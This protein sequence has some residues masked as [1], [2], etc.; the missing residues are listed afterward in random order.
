MARR[1]AKTAKPTKRRRPGRPPKH[2]GGD[3]ADERFPDAYLIKRYGNRRLYDARKSRA[4][5]LEGIAELVRRGEKVLVVDGDSGED[6]TRR[7]LTQILL[8]SQN[9]RLLELMPVELL[10]NLVSMRE[11]P[12]AK[13]METYLNAGAR[14]VNQLGKAGPDAK[15][16]KESMDNFFPWV[17]ADWVAPT[18]AP[19]ADE[20]L[21]DEMAE[22]QQRLADL[23]ARVN[24][25][26]R[27]KK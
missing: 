12:I 9:G 14:F 16:L 15:G 13:W 23:S 20:G 19:A 8:E 5:S 21:R 22:L 10:R 3:D 25:A 24:S 4:T 27:S 2:I 26:P 18:A 6:I 1:A 11:G 17:K 7:V